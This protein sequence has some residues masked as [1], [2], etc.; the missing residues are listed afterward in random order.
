MTIMEIG[1]IIIIIVLLNILLFSSNVKKK[2]DFNKFWCE[3][4]FI[5]KTYNV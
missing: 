3:L 5:N 4:D 1:M 2:T